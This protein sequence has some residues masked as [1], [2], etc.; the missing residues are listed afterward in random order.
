MIKDVKTL[1]LKYWLDYIE[2]I[3]PKDVEFGLDRIREVAVKGGLDKVDIP[4]I[5]VAG[6]NTKG[7]TVALLT[8][9]LESV[10]LNVGTY[11]SPHLV[12]FNERVTV[13]S[14]P[15]P[16][17]FFCNAFAKIESL[18]EDTALT[19]YEFVTLAA[20]DIF[21]LF[22]L[23]VLVLEVGCGG[24][25][26]AVN[27][28]DPDVSILTSVDFDH[29]EWLGDTLEKIGATKAGIFRPN[30]PA[31]IGKGAQ[32]SSVLDKAKEL[33]CT[34]CLEDDTFG[35]SDTNKT[36]WR[37]QTRTV[38]IPKHPLPSTCI[39]LALAAVDAIESQL[40]ALKKLEYDHLEPI[41]RK[42]QLPGRF[43]QLLLNH[44]VILDVAHNAKGADWLSKRLQG[45]PKLSKT[46]A[47]WSSFEDKDL[48]KI[49]EP[50][51]DMVDT[52]FIAPTQSA[53]TASLSDLKKALVKSNANDVYECMSIT[54]AFDKAQDGHER[55]SRILVFGSFATV[56]EVLGGIGQELSYLNRFYNALSH[57]QTIRTE[58][59]LT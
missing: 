51:S 26:D 13:N 17:H 21:K 59:T 39:S 12:Y 1:S 16:E 38:K 55:P 24:E 50:F 5:T 46:V 41:L 37:S 15:V 43:Q 35:W 10:G 34:M 30:K 57:E 45:L 11:F 58:A 8:K 36:Y 54:E 27:L 52:W 29:M 9:L 14:T 6:T 22:D 23:D 32:L 40:P 28:I 48:D 33:G 19:Y 49:I 2:S 47:V 3:H 7:S 53:R 44:E 18:R 20:F 25:K 42:A 31:I 4:V 56:G